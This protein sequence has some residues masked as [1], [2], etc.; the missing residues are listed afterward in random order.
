MTIGQIMAPIRQASGTVDER[1]IVAL[2]KRAR[3]DRR[4]E[5]GRGKKR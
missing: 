3:A 1:E 4:R 5:A 2:V